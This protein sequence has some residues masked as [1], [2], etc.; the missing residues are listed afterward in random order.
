M[1]IIDGR[2]LAEKI[3]DEVVEEIA[4]GRKGDELLNC[5]RPNLAIVL[6]GE[7]EDSKIYVNLKEREAKRVGI[8]THLY[9]LEEN[10]SEKELL[11]TIAFLNG[12]DQVDAILVQL[13]LPSHIDTDKVIQAVNP[14]KDVDGFHPDNLNM[15]LGTCDNPPVMPPVFDAVLE[16]LSSIKYELRGEQVCIVANS[17]IF[18]R[19]LAK[20]MECRGAKAEAVKPDDVK[21]EDK[22]READVLI[23][24][25]GKP[26]FIGGDMVKKGAV[27]IDIGISK[28]AGKVAG[29]IDFDDVD[30]MASF[31]TPVPGGIGPLTIACAFRNAVALFKRRCKK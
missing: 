13:P 29:D 9:K 26:G 25:V 27:L 28:E 17:D 1:Q 2:A 4:G 18:G 23:T 21:L 30:D 11:E 15:L 16:A 20:V 31:I 19:S 3:K 14:E 5:P 8:D 7:R 10:V 12:D 22:T 24:A 6:V